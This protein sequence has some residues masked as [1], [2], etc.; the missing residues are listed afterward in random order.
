MNESIINLQEAQELANEKN[1][2][3]YKFKKAIG[4]QPVTKGYYSRKEV[5]QGV[6]QYKPVVMPKFEKYDK[7]NEDV[8]CKSCYRTGLRLFQY[9]FCADCLN[10]ISEAVNETTI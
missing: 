4:L 3:W 6:S 10:G 9:N 1:G 8:H 2:A 5:E 7:A